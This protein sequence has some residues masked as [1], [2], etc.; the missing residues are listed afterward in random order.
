MRETRVYEVDTTYQLQLH[1]LL[2]AVLKPYSFCVELKS[3]SFALQIISVISVKG[4]AEG[5]ESGDIYG[6]GFLPKNT[7]F[8]AHKI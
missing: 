8:L 6:F 4:V 5:D 7:A 2:C 3:Y 1:H